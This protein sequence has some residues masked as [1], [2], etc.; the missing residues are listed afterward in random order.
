MEVIAPLTEHTHTVILLHGRDSSATEFA[1]EFLESQTSDGR[2]LPEIFPTVKWVFPRAM[3][4]P[5]ARFGIELSQWFDMWSTEDPYDCGRESHQSLVDS[6]IYIQSIIQDEIRVLGCGKKIFLGG[7]SQGC[8]TAIATLMDQEVE[9]GAFLGFCG[10]F[11]AIRCRPS[12]AWN[13]PVFLAHSQDDEVVAIRHGERLRDCLRSG[14][15]AVTWRSYED[16]GHWV[17]EPQG[18]NDLVDFMRT[19]ITT[20]LTS[21]TGL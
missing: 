12:G 9:L 4:I 16:G 3:V 21:D 2:Y 1:E 15:M 11:P 14:S 18:V 19:S 13:T 10:W 5:S 6:A 7:I 8:A 17:H 20:S